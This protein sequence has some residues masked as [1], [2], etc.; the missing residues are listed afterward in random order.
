MMESVALVLGLSLLGYLVLRSIE[1]ECPQY[2]VAAS[3]I[4]GLYMVV[5]LVVLGIMAAGQGA[6]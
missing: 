5:L 6:G 3:G 2:F 1:Q 4:Y